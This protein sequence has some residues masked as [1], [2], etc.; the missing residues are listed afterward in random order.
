MIGAVTATGIVSLSCGTPTWNDVGLVGDSEAPIGRELRWSNGQLPQTVDPA[1]ISSR[2]DSDLVRAVYEGLTDIEPETLRA[3]PAVAKSWSSEGDHRIHTFSLRDDARWTNGEAVTA[4]DFVRSWKR[5][6]A[7]RVPGIG[8]HLMSNIEGVTPGF[9]LDADASV[10]VEEVLSSP[11]DREGSESQQGSRR[12]PA[13]SM[14]ISDFGVEASG[15]LTLVVR[16]KNPD[17]DFPS[18]VAHPIFRPVHE[19]YD[20]AIANGGKVPTNGSFEVSEF[21]EGSVRLVRSATHRDRESISLESVSLVRHGSAEE[22]LSAYRGGSVDAVTNADFE[23]LALRLLESYGDFKSTAHAALNFYEF[24]LDRAPLND[25]RVR[26]AMSI[27][28]SRERLIDAEMG[29]AARPAL[30]LTPFDDVAEAVALTEDSQ[31]ARSLLSEAGFPNGAGF[32][33]LRLVVVRNDLQQRIAQAAARMWRQELNIDVEVVVRDRSEIASVR[34]S[35]DFD[36]IRRGV[37]FHT[38]SRAAALQAIFAPSSEGGGLKPDGGKRGLFEG[39]SLSESSLI[40]ESVVMPLYFPVSFSL[41]KPHVSGFTL[42][43][44]D[45]VDLKTVSVANLKEAAD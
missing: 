27:A 40:G 22:A 34:E 32:P 9:P 4:D 21:A 7:A 19:D 6:A 45:L 43:S 33:R 29:G 42:N 44:L 36:L 17:P 25:A 23:P 1:R 8:R 39:G 28:I 18:V 13:G 24:N 2:S 41:V 31:R 15:P 16:L 20:R 26:S 14:V 30:R 35:G 5:A 11:S 10:D 12:P 37:V 38:P 3:V